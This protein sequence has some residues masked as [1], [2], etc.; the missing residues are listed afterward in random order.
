MKA[1]GRGNNPEAP[2]LNSRGTRRLLWT[3]RWGKEKGEKRA[4]KVRILPETFDESRFSSSNMTLLQNFVIY[5]VVF[6]QFIRF[7]VKSATAFPSL[8]DTIFPW[9]ESLEFIMLILQKW[10]FPLLTDE[11]KKYYRVWS[12]TWESLECWSVQHRIYSWAAAYEIV[13]NQI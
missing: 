13:L 3:G 11:E 9:L 4:G 7:R 8:L 1:K 10:R 5:R 6:N 2:F 12:F